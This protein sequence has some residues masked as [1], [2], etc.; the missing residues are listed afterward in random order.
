M[1]IIGRFK[2]LFRPHPH[3]SIKRPLPDVIKYDV[4]PFSE[5]K[6]LGE[7]GDGAFGSVQKVCSLSNPQR[8][9][10]AKVNLIKFSINIH[11]FS[12]HYN[13]RR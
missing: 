6:S 8:L 1:P 10:A 5:W 9:A 13:R 4:D 7:L 3:T 12:E 11:S 2:N